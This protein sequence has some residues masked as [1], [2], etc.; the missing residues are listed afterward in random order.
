[1]LASKSK[2]GSALSCE[3]KVYITGY[4]D[5]FCSKCF[6]RDPKC[7]THKAGCRGEV[8]TEVSPHQPKLVTTTEGGN[9]V[10]RLCNT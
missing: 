2:R 3:D 9:V 7:V 10:T 5:I 8:Y 1:M 4:G 6:T